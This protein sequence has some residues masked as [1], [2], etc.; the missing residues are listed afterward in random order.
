MSNYLN[1]R[2]VEELIGAINGNR[3]GKD[4]KG[5]SHVEAYEIRAHL[6]R[7]FGFARWSADLLDFRQV[8]EDGDGGKWTVCYVATV[9]LTV[10]ASDGTV[11][12]TYTEAA[13]G[14]AKNQ[15]HRGDAHDLAVKTAE[16][17]AFKRC[18]VNLG[19]AFGLSLY[20]KGS[21]AP[22]VKGTLV[23]PAGGAAKAP[24]PTER[25][26]SHITEPL[27]QESEQVEDKRETNQPPTPPP[28][29]TPKENPELTK[30]V[31]T[32][33]VGPDKDEAVAP[34]YAR[35]HVAANKGKFLNSLVENRD[36]DMVSAGALLGDEQK[37][38][39]RERAA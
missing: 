20:R 37:R 24:A 11:L 10:C 6:S 19:D 3:V 23:M 12:A 4:G 39:Q 31:R 26:D 14:E 35:M 1:A 5:H 15:P 18:A 30:W 22:L 38:T 25:I 17:Q 29:A 2:Q 36:G 16:S 33:L 34:F 32:L 21:L 8:Y 27:P 13:T 28:A 9:R 7:I